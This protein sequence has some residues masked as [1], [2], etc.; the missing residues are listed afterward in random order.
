MCASLMV[1]S[2]KNNDPELMVVA[3]ESVPLSEFEYL[4]N[5][6]S[7]QQLNPQSMD[8]YLGLFVNYK[9]KV[10]DAVSEGLDTTEAFVREYAKFK[11]EL[12]EPYFKDQ[13]TLD[14]LVNLVTDRMQWDVT[15]S[16][17]MMPAGS[18]ASLD[19]L[20]N[21]IVSGQ[22]TFNSVAMG[23]SIDKPSAR[24]GGLMGVV[25]PLRYPAAF[26]AA[27]YNTAVGEISPVVNSGLGLHLIKVESRTPAKG[28]VKASHILRMTRGKSEEEQA[29]AKVTI[30]SIYSVLKADPSK[31]EELAKAYSQDGSAAKGGDL[32][33][34]GPGMMVAEFDSVAYALA[35]NEISEPFATQFGWHIVKKTGNRHITS[36]ADDRE[37]VVNAINRSNLASMPAD[38]YFD[39][40]KKKYNV[41]W[42]E[43]N[44]DSIAAPIIARDGHL[45]EG[46]LNWFMGCDIPVISVNDYDYTVAELSR[47]GKFGG[48]DGTHDIMGY[49]L[50][51]A[52]Y[53]MK[54][55]V[56]DLAQ[57]ELAASNA[58]YNNLIK[59]YRD[60]ILL[61]EVSNSKVWDKATKDNEGLEKY[62]RG[63]RDRYTWDAPR[64]KSYIIF[65]TTD[66]ILD[67]AMK[68]AETMPAD[69]ASTQL[70]DAM[71]AKYGRDVK[72]ERVIAAKGENPITDY[73]GFGADKPAASAGRWSFYAP[74]RGR[75]IN[76]PEE[77]TDVRGAVVSD[78]QNELEQAWLAELHKKYPVKINHK[79]LKKVK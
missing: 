34:F 49:L 43:E 21:L 60:G 36:S 2:A 56:N 59:E 45:D 18:E 79:V 57:Q 27:A 62:F 40:L 61:F 51:L 50:H 35:D 39:K 44:Y 58:D 78:Y 28:E 16:H 37:R 24:R 63:H 54:D 74:F 47:E 9:L 55:V 12:S 20:R 25:T 30:D 10:A 33:W 23:N 42:H 68:L 14:S 5:K 6:N 22:Q 75:I 77:A 19:S 76:A 4:Y 29:R 26:E 13:A 53:K 71:K 72:V 69:V 64:F 3:G 38:V 52:E 11:K 31:F 7:T 67:S 65:A 46:L 70:V 32:G 1:L 8:D 17:I 48:H 15:V 73:L 41:V 66:S